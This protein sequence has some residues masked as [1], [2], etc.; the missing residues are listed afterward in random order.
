[1]FQAVMRSH[2][3]LSRAGCHLQRARPLRRVTVHVG[4]G[5][6]CKDTWLFKSRITKYIMHEY[7]SCQKCCM[8]NRNF[9]LQT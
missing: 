7:L 9:S 6:S 1:M 8:I 5:H 2:P 3:S 4:Q